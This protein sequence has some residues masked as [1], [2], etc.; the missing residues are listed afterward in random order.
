MQ[1]KT[2]AK[3]NIRPLGLLG[4]LLAIVTMT[5]C[6]NGETS[7]NP[8]A[9]APPPP[10]WEIATPDFSF[11][12]D[13]PVITLQGAQ[14]ML[15]NIGEAFIDPG[16]TSN[17]AQ[18]GNLS[19]EISVDVQLDNTQAGDYF[20]R[21]QVS[22][23]SGKQAI[24]AIRI[25]RVVEDLPVD[26]SPRPV[27]TTQSHLGYIEYLP[28]DYGLDPERKYPLLIYNHGNGANVEFAGNDPLG[29][30]GAL[31]QNAGPPLLLNA[32]QWDPDLPFVVLVPQFGNVANVDVPSRI[33]AFVDFA[34]N[35]YGIDESQVYF[36]GWSQGG[37]L[38]FLYAIEHPDRVAA[39][40][41]ISG[42]IPLDPDALPENFCNIANVPVWAF[43][44]N[45]DDVVPFESSIQ[46]INL[47]E[48]NCQ[49]KIRPRLTILEDRD[50]VIHH[51][52]F[53]LTAMQGGNLGYTSDP[54]FDPYDQSIFEWLLS[55]DLDDR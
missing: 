8:N 51:S 48:Q 5:A 39:I 10:Y 25:L 20:V 1:R 13:R 22:D 47:I 24:D 4:I 43:H 9:V 19:D 33:D 42:G 15:L 55:F 16:A 2:I 44:G 23:S 6:S 21:Y 40:I 46:S 54:N 49:P 37:F 31:L 52:V 38:S 53:N 30:L 26:I 7:A 32:G 17:D 29:A 50:H 14:V 11:D 45:Q 36:T 41:S 18:D 27:G 28:D 34:I 35:T 3:S 12:P